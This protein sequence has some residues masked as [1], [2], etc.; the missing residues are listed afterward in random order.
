[1]IEVPVYNEKGQQIET[2]QVEESAFGT[3]VRRKLL[4]QAIVM[5]E[6]NKRQGTVATRSRGMVA[7]ST[8]KLYA[9]KHTGRARMG[10][11]RT[12]VRRGGGVAFRKEPHDWSLSMPQKAKKSALDSAL[13]SK[14]KD[15]G[16]M[17]I[18]KLGTG[19][20]TTKYI[21]TVLKALKLNEK[22]CLIGI[23]GY[24]K[25]IYLSVRNMADVAV[26]PVAEFNAYDVLKYRKV[27]VT[28][29]GFGK[30]AKSA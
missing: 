1:M 24:D 18:D 8:R 4:K 17:I 19:S 27:L 20:P 11:I 26:M 28:K 6:A 21:A 15:G 25:N 2:M 7:G 14:L 16:L 5:Y 12:N 22:T 13:L 23:G 9:Q 10:P 3:I 30:L 29:D